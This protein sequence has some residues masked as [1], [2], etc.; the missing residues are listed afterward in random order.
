ML[1]AGVVAIAVAVSGCGK[2]NLPS[3]GRGGTSAKSG[4]SGPSGGTERAQGGP[5][6]GSPAGSAPAP[7]HVPVPLPLTRARAEAFAHR[8]ELVPVD[9][10]GAR[11]GSEEHA[12]PQA[13][14]EAARCGSAAS[15]LASAS[16]GKLHRGKG[17]AQEDISSSVEVL[18]SAAMVQ[19]NL[20]YLRSRAGVDCY[21]KVLR[22][23]LRREES[24]GLRVI[25]LRVARLQVG[26]GEGL[27]I[28]ATVSLAEGTGAV[29]VFIDSLA[30][31][32]GPAEV[33]LYATS[34]VQP[35]PTRTEQELLS[36]LRERAALVRL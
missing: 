34:F 28:E 3:A 10:P 21:G 15:V 11:A 27:R 24:D 1:A 4:G 23:D 17:L 16:S 13:E 33:D 29:R 22:N 32:Y 18:G 31:G 6:G 25:G 30:L 2:S 5:P 7:A 26:A 9:V 12:D 35:E 36:L 8:V 20:N 19:D 14:R